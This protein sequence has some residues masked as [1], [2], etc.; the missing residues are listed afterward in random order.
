MRDRWGVTEGSAMCWA[1]L[2][3]PLPAMKRPGMWEGKCRM[4]GG[5]ERS[6]RGE[7]GR[8]SVVGSGVNAVEWKK[9]K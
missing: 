1:L 4:G 8:K 2:N 6:G 7:R 5:I 9:V 3:L